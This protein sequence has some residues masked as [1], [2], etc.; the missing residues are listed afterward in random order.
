MTEVLLE[1]G[2]AM[3]P[4]TLQTHLEESVYGDSTFQSNMR[5]QHFPE[6]A[7][8]FLPNFK[9]FSDTFLILKNFSIND[10]LSTCYILN[11][12]Q[13]SCHWRIFV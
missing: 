6:A 2:L 3:V 7:L 4:V 13:F 8:G 9:S 10:L 5:P 11:S 12:S 1:P